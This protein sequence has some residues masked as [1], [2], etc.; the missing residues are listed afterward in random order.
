MLLI[1]AQAEMGIPADDLRK[2]VIKIYA[3]AGE[4]DF[5]TL[6]SMP[7]PRYAPEKRGRKRLEDLED[8]KNLTPKEIERLVKQRKREER[9]R[10]KSVIQQIADEEGSTYGAISNLMHDLSVALGNRKV[11]RT[12]RM[13]RDIDENKV[14]LYNSIADIIREKFRNSL[15]QTLILPNFLA[16]HNLENH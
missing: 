3:S 8:K 4:P 10:E 11:G 14:M 13:P 6:E 5:E 16:R 2:Q 7:A 9:E 12:K 1:K 15:V